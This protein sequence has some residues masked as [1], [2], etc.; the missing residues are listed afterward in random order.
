MFSFFC[1]GRSR[2]SY[3]NEIDEQY[4]TICTLEKEVS[5]TYHELR[6]SEYKV[7]LQSEKVAFLE[8]LLVSYKNRMKKQ[9]QVLSHLR[10]S[11][12]TL[13]RK[14][15]SLRTRTSIRSKKL[16]TMLQSRTILINLFIRHIE[17]LTQQAGL[18][19]SGDISVVTRGSYD[20]IEGTNIVIGTDTLDGE[21]IDCI[22][23]YLKEDQLVTTYHPEMDSIMVTYYLPLGSALEVQEELWIE[24]QIE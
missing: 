3:Q 5:H 15:A 2:S 13:Y 23:G 1:C 21:E 11:A 12:S 4:E 7:S 9:Y 14:N 10:S 18:P 24:R 17:K 16:A 8:K 20:V 22:I 6:E 19:P